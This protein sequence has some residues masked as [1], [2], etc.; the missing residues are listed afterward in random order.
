V[1]DREKRGSA[2]SSRSPIA[3]GTTACSGFRFSGFWFRVADF[4]FRI[5]G[6]EFHASGFGSRV[7]CFGFRVSG[8]ELWVLG[9]DFHV[10]GFGVTSKVST[11][12]SAFPGEGLPGKTSEDLVRA[13]TA[14]ETAMGV[15]GTGPSAASV[16][17]ARPL[18]VRIPSTGRDSSAAIGTII[19]TGVSAG[20]GEDTA[21][22]RREALSFHEED[23]KAPAGVETS[24]LVKSCPVKDGSARVR[25]SPAVRSISGRSVSVMF[26]TWPA[27]NGE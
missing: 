16:E 17:S 15:T 25:V 2:S 13:P 27:W 10:S 14:G 9:F 21:R 7:P 23:R 26:A 5:S 4:E 11:A 12:R 22:M 3:I 19:S 20:T 8:F 1:E 18:R 24:V 6:F